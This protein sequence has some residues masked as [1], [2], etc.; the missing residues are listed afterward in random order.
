MD[1]KGQLFTWTI[2]LGKAFIH[3]EC[4]LLCKSL[5]GNDGSICLFKTLLE[6]YVGLSVHQ[7]QSTVWLSE[8]QIEVFRSF[9]ETLN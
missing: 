8:N 5:D 9:S 3:F 6:F 7:G 4:I 1:P 2:I